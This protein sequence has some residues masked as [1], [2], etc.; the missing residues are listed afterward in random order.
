MARI[1]GIPGLIMKNFWAT[2]PP[3]PHCQ[4]I[5]HIKSFEMNKS[6]FTPLILFATIAFLGCSKKH[7]S[8]PKTLIIQ[9][10]VIDSCFQVSNPISYLVNI[11]SSNK[12]YETSLY[13]IPFSNTEFF[14]SG[15]WTNL[16]YQFDF[17]SSISFQIYFKFPGDNQVFEEAYGAFSLNPADYQSGPNAY[18][19]KIVFIGN[20]GVNQTQLTL[21]VLWK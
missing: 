11:A 21:V 1:I 6:F 9:N 2:K 16:N 19:P 14:P 4:T 18:P 7:D 5:Y 17:N 12:T 20:P 8:K 3:L 13:D 10:I 15:I